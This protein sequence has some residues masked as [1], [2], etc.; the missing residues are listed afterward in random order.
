MAAVLQE[1]KGTRSRKWELLTT[2]IVKMVVSGK[3]V[4]AWVFS[5]PTQDSQRAGP[6]HFRTYTF[7][8]CIS[9]GGIA[10]FRFRVRF[11]ALI[12]LD[13]VFAL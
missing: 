1:L 11:E 8:F 4:T 10:E 7:P 12:L 2:E 13:F 6:L 3:A 9:A 5:R